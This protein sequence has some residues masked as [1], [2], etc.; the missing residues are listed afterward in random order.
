MAAPREFAGPTV[1]GYTPQVV[2]ISSGITGG[3]AGYPAL[4]VSLEPDT[5]VGARYRFKEDVAITQIH[6]A[7]AAAF[8]LAD[9]GLFVAV[10]LR[11][12]GV[13]QND[14]GSTSIYIAHRYFSPA[15]IAATPSAMTGQASRVTFNPDGAIRVNSN[16]E[17]CFFWGYGAI[18]AAGNW[19]L[20]ATAQVFYVP[21]AYGVIPGNYPP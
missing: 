12:Q 9:K 3:N 16:S 15:A 18:N 7:S 11:G 13:P 21:L 1:F 14:N 4:S 10:G 2:T 5:A 17:I 6:L 8:N 20:T 19:Q